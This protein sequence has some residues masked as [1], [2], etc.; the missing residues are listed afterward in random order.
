MHDLQPEK[1]K[2]SQLFSPRN[3]H[4]IKSHA[5]GNKLMAAGSAKNTSPILWL[6]TNCGV[7]LSSEEW[8]TNY[9]WIQNTSL[10][11]REDCFYVFVSSAPFFSP[12]KFWGKGEILIGSTVCN[13]VSEH[14]C[15]ENGITSRANMTDYLGITPNAWDLLQDQEVCCM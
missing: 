4:I 6:C 11:S 5:S 15:T 2:H 3:K 8:V 7:W 1:L 10:R 13:G 14:R 9:C 12:S